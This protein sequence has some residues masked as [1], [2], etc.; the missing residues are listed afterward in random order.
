MKDGGWLWFK[1]DGA[2]LEQRLYAIMI[3]VMIC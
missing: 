3:G 2:M 1:R